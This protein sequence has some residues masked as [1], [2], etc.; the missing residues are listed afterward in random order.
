[1]RDR[2]ALHDGPIAGKQSAGL[3]S[4]LITI[5]DMVSPAPWRSVGEALDKRRERMRL[6]IDIGKKA[7]DV[8]ALNAAGRIIQR[9]KFSRNTLMDFLTPH[10]EH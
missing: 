7:F 5:N 3:F 9:A 2:L 10:R 8:V 1:M 4:R 6:K